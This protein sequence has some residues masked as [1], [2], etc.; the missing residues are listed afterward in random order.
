[1]SVCAP[2]GSGKSHF[3]KNVLKAGLTDDYDKV[4]FYCPSLALNEDYDDFRLQNIID[5][6]HGDPIKYHF[7]SDVSP[8]NINNLMNQLEELKEKEITTK[9][10]KKFNPYKERKNQIPWVTQDDGDNDDDDD[11]R[12]DDSAPRVLIVLDDCI[13]ENVLNFRGLLDRVANRGRHFNCSMIILSQRMSAISRGIR[14]NSDYFMIFEPWSISEFEQFI[15]KFVPQG[16]QK[17][18][19]QSVSQL[20]ETEYTFLLLDHHARGKERSTKNLTYSTT[21]DFLKNKRYTI[22]MIPDKDKKE[23]D[24]K[25]TRKRKQ[26]AQSP[27]DIQ[28]MKRSKQ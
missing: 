1:M 9:R 5:E 7:I 23:K 4:V 27:E 15:K 11:D 8:D 10:N 17:N 28:P 13:D 18:F 19:L 24:E 14:I 2:R 3:T 6:Q 25:K 16:Y 26:K 21:D 20:F 12:D 22:Q